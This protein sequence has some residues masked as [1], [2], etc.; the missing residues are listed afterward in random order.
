[1][2]LRKL[3]EKVLDFRCV[4]KNV[5]CF[6]TV[7]WYIYVLNNPLKIKRWYFP[8]MWIQQNI[9]SSTSKYKNFPLIAMYFFSL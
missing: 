4:Y 7:F 3:T 1:M 5:S 9:Y 6:V 8:V 2:L